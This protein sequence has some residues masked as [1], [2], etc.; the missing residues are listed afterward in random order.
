MDAGNRKEI[1]KQNSF[2][3]VPCDLGRGASR[4]DHDVREGGVCGQNIESQL[5]DR[6]ADH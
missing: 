3:I 2:G 1:F 6:A 5:F 4:A